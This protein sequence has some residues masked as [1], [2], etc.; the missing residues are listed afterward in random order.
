MADALDFRPLGV[1]AAGLV[2]HG[3][4]IG[5]GSGR[6]AEAFIRAL[7]DWVKA[8]QDVRGVPTSERSHQLALELGIP[9]ITLAD[10]PELDADFDGADEVDPAGNLIKGWGGALVR[11]KIVAAASKKFVVLVGE[12]KLVPVLG[13]KK[14]LPVEIVPFAEPFALRELR[15]LGLGPVVRQKDGKTFQS[16]NGNLVVDCATGPIADAA[17]LEVAIHTIPGVVGTGLFVGMATTVLV[18]K[19]DEVEVREIRPSR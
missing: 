4:N 2:R 19:P 6:A 7:G 13:T 16:D 9:T 14:K 12:E 18:Q 10:V 11:E 5:L 1:K 15:K 8:G 17:A 3:A